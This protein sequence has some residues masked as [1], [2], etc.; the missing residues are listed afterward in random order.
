VKSQL[1][2]TDLLSCY[3]L[4]LPALN[5]N[6]CAECDKKISGLTA[7]EGSQLSL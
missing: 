5:E 7:K 1:T 2:Q 3:E 6:T 4:N